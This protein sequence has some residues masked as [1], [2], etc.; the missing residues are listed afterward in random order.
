MDI[1]GE[2]SIQFFPDEGSGSAGNLWR[3]TSVPRSQLSYQWLVIEFWESYDDAGATVDAEY[4]GGTITISYSTASDC[5]GNGVVM[6]ANS[7]PTQTGAAVC[8]TS[9]KA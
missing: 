7:A 8:S 3:P 9:A 1:N 2:L 4:T 5:N 6:P